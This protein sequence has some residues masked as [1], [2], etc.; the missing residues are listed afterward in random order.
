MHI[1]YK[2]LDITENVMISAY[3]DSV[4]AWNTLATKLETTLYQ[5]PQTFE[6]LLGRL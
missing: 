6:L 2:K 1:I 4:N 5:I 3:I